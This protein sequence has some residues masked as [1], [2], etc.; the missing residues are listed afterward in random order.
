MQQFIS[1]LR[2]TKF[3]LF[4]LNRKM[5]LFYSALESALFHSAS[6]FI[7]TNCKIDLFSI[8]WQ[9]LMHVSTKKINS[10]FSIWAKPRRSGQIVG[11]YG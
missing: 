4:Y 9:I 3:D 11:F 5:H 7:G 8:L 6:I 2:N 1:V 10:F